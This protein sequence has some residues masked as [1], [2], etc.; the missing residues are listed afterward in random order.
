MG[1]LFSKGYRKLMSEVE[2]RA[3]PG[4]AMP[5]VKVYSRAQTRHLFSRFSS[6]QLKVCHVYP[7]R[8]Q[9]K[10]P[11]LRR[12]LEKYLGWFGWYIVAVATK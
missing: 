2:Y 8:F 3:D 7:G 11:W 12:F 10:A 5:I 6:V 4:T 1:G 9:K